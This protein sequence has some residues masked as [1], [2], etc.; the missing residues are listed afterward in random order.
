MFRSQVHFA[1]K[2]ACCKTDDCTYRN[3]ESI[4]QLWIGCHFVND[5]R[6]HCHRNQVADHGSK[7]LALERFARSASFPAIALSRDP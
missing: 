5:D 4:P 6:E 2:Y 3:P 7:A 1:A